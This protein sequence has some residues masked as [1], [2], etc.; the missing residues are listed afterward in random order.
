VR[1]T[2]PAGFPGERPQT[3][4][5]VPVSLKGDFTITVSFEILQEP[6]GAAA[7]KRGTKATLGALLDT[8]ELHLARL[9][10]RSNVEEGTQ[11]STWT[12]SGK[13]G[14]FAAFAT[15]AKSGRLRLV[16][17]GA[18][19]FYYVAE[20]DAAQFNLLNERP[21]SGADVKEIQIAG[22]TGGPEAALDARFRD[23]RV[24]ADVVPKDSRSRPTW[25]RLEL[26][27]FGIVI[28][29]AAALATGSWMYVRR[30][31]RHAPAPE[32]ARE[33]GAPEAEQ[34]TLIRCTGCGKQ[35]RTRTELAGKQLQ[36]PHCGA[37]VR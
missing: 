28:V 6:E 7:G 18:A 32:A 25:G 15:T 20:G 11:F 35:L 1:I 17:T 29:L 30:R 2:L 33:H 4:L 3:G 14:P 5:S 13:K 22:S 31:R 10:R 27:G 23:L 24:G 8:P 21:F 16:R 9:A 12:K 19:I 36:C 37:I 34:T 26:L